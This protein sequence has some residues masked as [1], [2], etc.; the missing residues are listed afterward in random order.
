MMTEEQIEAKIREKYPKIDKER[1]CRQ[2]KQR[3][4]ALRA[5]YREKLR[6]EAYTAPTLN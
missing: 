1:T 5:F 2:E 3:R 6:T 4:E